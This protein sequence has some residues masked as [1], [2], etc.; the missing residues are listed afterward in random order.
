MIANAVTASRLVL[1]LPLFVLLMLPSDAAHWTALG[2]L[3]LAGLTD[4]VDGRIARAMNQASARGAML[5]LIADRVLTATLAVGLIAGGAL[6]GWWAL[7]ALVL[8]GRDLAVSSFGEA[9]RGRA[10]FPVTLVEK[11]KIVL[12][13]GG[14]AL[15]VAP[16]LMAPQHDVGHWALAASA[17]LALYTL[18]GYA[19]RATEALNHRPD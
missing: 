7:P 17:I 13:F 10:K 18:A 1:A 19:R 2:V 4:V 16:E 6:S 14:F 9:T 8:L 11:V 3:V 15:L 12:Q 5:D